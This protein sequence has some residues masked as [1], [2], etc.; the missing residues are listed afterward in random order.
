MELVP[1][2][3]FD[4]EEIEGAVGLEDMDTPVD[5]GLLVS[6]AGMFSA[7]AVIVPELIFRP[8]KAQVPNSLT[9]V[10]PTEVPLTN[11]SIVE[12]SSSVAEP[13]MV[14][15]GLQYDPVTA[16]VVD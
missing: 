9:V 15:T 16:G 1:S 4:H 14:S 7:V 3:T 6:Q 2:E 5:A 8:D 11:T 10:V 12:P 13:K